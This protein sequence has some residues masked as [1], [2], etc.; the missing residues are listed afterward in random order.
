MTTQD[1][2]EH[3]LDTLLG[4][5]I[6]KSIAIAV[7]GG[8][9]SMALLHLTRN[10]ARAK[11]CKTHA[12]TID[13]GLRPEAKDEADFVAKTCRNLSVPHSILSWK[14][15]PGTG[16]LQAQAREARYDL[17]GDWARANDIPVLLL[18]HTSDDQAETVLMRLARGSGVDGLAG[19]PRKRQDRQVQ[20]LR[21]LLNI[22]RQALRDDLTTIGAAWIDDPSND[23]PR[24]DRV[25]AR[26]L[27]QALAPMGLTQKRL[28]QMAQHMAD[29]RHVLE[30]ATKKLAEDSV[31]IIAGS[32][33]IETAI[34]RDAPADLR[35]RLLAHALCWVSQQTYRPRF[36]ALTKLARGL[37]Q[38]D[39]G[40]L[41]GAL[42]FQKAD[43][44]WITRELKAVAKTSFISDQTWDGRWRMIGPV[45]PDQ[46]IR[47]LGDEG[48]ARCEN[49]RD[50]GLPRQVLL[51]SPAIWHETE[52]IAAPFAGHSN[53]WTAELMAN[54]DDF[55]TSII[56]H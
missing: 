31:Q 29:A 54:H 33:R 44:I 9:D 40:S 10:W 4:G 8:G 43:H 28:V 37:I 48:L 12:V 45:K 25:K 53:G 11:S 27:M 55:F 3:N 18:G 13:H 47:A 42:V 30:I 38:G 19:M 35:H 16:N 6:P 7:S 22:S 34:W 46:R 2:F 32:V 51:S 52:L 36:S 1:A 41:H 14:Q 15:H 5:I 39:N 49:W 24:F 17:I 23:D 20:W 21:P 56:T 50:T 26:Q